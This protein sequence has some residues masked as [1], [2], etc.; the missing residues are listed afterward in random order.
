M[1]VGLILPSFLVFAQEIPDIKVPQDLE[2]AKEIGERA[3]ETTKKELPGKIKEIWQEDVLPIWEKMYQ[4]S[5]INI[6]SKIEQWW[7]KNVW[8]RKP[9]IE[10][11]FEKEKQEM[12]KEVQEQ[13]PKIWQIISQKIKDIKEF[14]GIGN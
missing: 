1:T 11:E 5:K 7:Q 10:Q 2:E 12:A 14:L 3:Y 9:A 4:W 8:P 13:G 6:F